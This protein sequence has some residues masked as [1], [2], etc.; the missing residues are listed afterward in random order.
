[1]RASDRH[2]NVLSRDAKGLVTVRT[3]DLQVVEAALWH[4]FASLA[5]IGPCRYAAAGLKCPVIVV[6]RSAKER[7]FAERKATFL[8]GC[9]IV[10]QAILSEM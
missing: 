5:R 7:P 4:D 2:A 6:F 1:M 9:G 3:S 8:S 10:S